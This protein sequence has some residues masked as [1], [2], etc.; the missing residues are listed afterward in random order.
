VTG[1]LENLGASSV[2]IGGRS[3]PGTRFSLTAT[4]FPRREFWI[5]AGGRILKASTPDRGIVAVRDEPPR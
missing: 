2:E 1:N 5:D 3:I 4:G